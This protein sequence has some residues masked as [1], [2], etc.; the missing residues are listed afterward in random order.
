M[1][2]LKATAKLSDKEILFIVGDHLVEKAETWWNVVGSKSES[3]K[4]FSELFK[5]QYMGLNERFT[6]HIFASL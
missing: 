2:R 6:V 3:W 5:K 1:S 4:E